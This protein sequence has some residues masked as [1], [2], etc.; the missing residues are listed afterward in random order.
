MHLI[1][2]LL[3]DLTS[4]IYRISGLFIFLTIVFHGLFIFYRPLSLPNW[5]L[6]EYSWVILAF[7]STLGLVDESRRINAMTTLTHTQIKV[8]DAKIKVTDWFDSYQDLTCN[9]QLDKLRCATF[10]K[11]L[12][13]I[14]LLTLEEELT[15]EFDKSLLNSLSSLS[16]WLSNT[17]MGIIND[18]VDGYALQ[19]DQFLMLKQQIKRSHFQKLINSLTP[20]LLAFALALKM[21][22]VTAEHLALRRKSKKR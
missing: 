18:R 16:P 13:D 6:V 1:Y 5:K 10:T 3:S 22:K 8:E 7:V 4:D 17:S 11:I 12:N 14:E 2:S 21:T 9:E 20:L 19:R 15:P